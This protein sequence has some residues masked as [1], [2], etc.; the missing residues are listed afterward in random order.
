MLQKK[1]LTLLCIS[2]LVTSMAQ[3]TSSRQSP[4]RGEAAGYSSRD[5]TTL[6]VMGWGVGLAVGIATL[7][8]LLNDG[9]GSSSHSH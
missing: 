6:S 1:I 4:R 8:V 3:E 2:T 5:A 9:T 7:A